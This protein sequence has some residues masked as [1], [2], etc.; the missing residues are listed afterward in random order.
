MIDTWATANAGSD[1]NAAGLDAAVA[2]Q[3]RPHPR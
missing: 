2:E 1:E 3:V